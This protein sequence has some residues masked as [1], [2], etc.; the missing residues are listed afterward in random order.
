MIIFNQNFEPEKPMICISKYEQLQFEDGILM[1]CS[2]SALEVYYE[3]DQ[4]LIDVLK[5]KKPY[6]ISR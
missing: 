1:G 2:H 6:L 5:K 3:I 4:D